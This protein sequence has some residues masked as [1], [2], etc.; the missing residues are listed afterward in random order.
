MSRAVL[1]LGFVASVAW[2][3]ACALGVESKTPNAMIGRW[4]LNLGRSH[5]GGGA[6]PRARETMVCEAT[7]DGIRCR[8]RSERIDARVL[9]ACFVARDDGTRAPVTGFPDEDAVRLVRVDDW[10]TDAT[11]YSRGRPVF[12]YRA[13]LSSNRKSLTIVSVDPATRAALHSV[14]VYDAR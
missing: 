13:V 4:E 1:S 6:E 11:F 9:T 8:I 10:I 5:Y 12:A 7:A 14:I 3:S 2:M